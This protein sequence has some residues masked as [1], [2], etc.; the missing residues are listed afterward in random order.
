MYPC[1]Y[2]SPYRDIWGEGRWQKAAKNQKQK[3]YNG[4]GGGSLFKNSDDGSTER[5]LLR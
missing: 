2:V 3:K 4:R 5:Y 1:I